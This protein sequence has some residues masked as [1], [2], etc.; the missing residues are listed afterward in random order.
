MSSDTIISETILSTYAECFGIFI[1]QINTLHSF[2]MKYVLFFALILQLAVG[3]SAHAQSGDPSV[4]NTSLLADVSLT[5]ASLV[6]EGRSANVSFTL[7]NN[8][9]VQPGVKYAVIL[10]RENE[11]VQTIEDVFVSAEE[12]TLAPAQ[13]VTRNIVYTAPQ[14][15][16]GT[17]TVYVQSANEAGF[18][19]GMARAG[20]L[21]L[22]EATAKLSLESGSCYVTAVDTKKYTS[23]E[24]VPL[25][26]AETLT[27][28]CVLKN[29]TAEALT[30]TPR[31]TTNEGSLYGPVTAGEGG[32]LASF[33]LAPNEEKTI[34]TELPRA[35]KGGTYAVTVS[36]DNEGSSES[37]RYHTAD[38]GLFVGNVMLDSGSYRKGDMANIRLIVGGKSAQAQQY[39]LDVEDRNG[40]SCAETVTGVLQ[41]TALYTNNT[42]KVLMTASCTN[43]VIK[44]QIV[45]KNGSIVSA[46]SY[47]VVLPISPSASSV[48]IEMDTSD[49]GGSGKAPLSLWFSI[50][51]LAV[52][53]GYF[54]HTLSKK[55]NMSIPPT[56]PLLILLAFVGFGF[57]SVPYAEAASFTQNNGACFVSTSY[58]PVQNIPTGQ[59][60]TASGFIS[61][62][63]DGVSAVLRDAGYGFSITSN[64]FGALS[65][66][67]PAPPADDGINYMSGDPG[68]DP[69]GLGNPFYPFDF[70]F[71][72]RCLPQIINN[73][74]T[75]D[76]AFFGVP[77][78]ETGGTCVAA[79]SCSY[80]CQP[81]LTW[82]QNSNT[83]GAPPPPPPGSVPA[84][85]STP[86]CVIAPNASSCSTT[87]DL[88][89]P[90]AYW[91]G[92]S[93]GTPGV[94]IASFM[95]GAHTTGV[96]I[97][98]AGQT[99]ELRP[100]FVGATVFATVQGTATCGAGTSWNG[101]VCNPVPPVP[102]AV[103][104]GLSTQTGASC[105]TRTVNVTWNPVANATSYDILRDGTVLL[106][107][108]VSPFA[109][110]VSVDG[111]THIYQVR[112]WAGGLVSA[113]SAPAVPGTA[114]A[115][116]PI[117]TG[118]LTINTCTI[119]DG[120]SSC[121]I[122]LSWM[123]TN[124]TAPSVRQ[125]GTI[126]SVASS[127]PGIPRTV[128]YG[129]TTF[130]LKDGT[131]ELDSE[132]ITIL[133]AS[134]SSW[135]NATC[136]STATP[137]PSVPCAGGEFNGCVV[138]NTAAGNTSGSCNTSTHTGT[139]SI[140]CSPSGTGSWV[141][142]GT[143]NCST[144]SVP[145][146]PPVTSGPTLTSPSRLVRQGTSVPITWDT[147]N[148]DEGL[149]TLTGGTLSGFITRDATDGVENG[150]VNQ[151]IVGRTTYALSCPS[152][153]T[154]L[155]IDVIP[156]SSET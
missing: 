45:E 72:N 25:K 149:C 20:T 83:C 141:L 135:N 84:F 96:T 132:I 125:D 124:T 156:S 15:F 122:N 136:E 37:Y 67:F 108:V 134:G 147:N 75:P 60:V 151:T 57:A 99:F 3:V 154:T 55:G 81:D 8:T 103:P 61:C 153:A 14:A 114:S 22:P 16:G 12:L 133:C 41:N 26:D 69:F 42:V 90:G 63:G 36:Y 1:L 58:D 13:S 105:G 98:Y 97:P 66:S 38:A 64:S 119:P 128:G 74:S 120:Q 65:G 2:F 51:G 87:V 104:A 76:A 59:T 62:P 18:V 77:V 27:S 11:A 106:S 40:A 148:G 113:W 24:L 152:G 85:T 146:P 5:G 101:T 107:G 121:Q 94:Y 91:T 68:P 144:I 43:P 78:G 52:G 88:F 49:E 46:D 50:I 44:I 80:T 54:Y 93:F 130:T 19:F 6:Q 145:P 31:F 142:P 150:T 35:Q 29:T 116:C 10:A 95:P 89:V 118:A 71:V 155:T 115:L 82:R 100:A 131:T 129:N 79:G 7:T 143:N 21:T 140:Q 127:S 110:T 34:V 138:Q 86:S 102:P 117:A 111:T 56:T 137:P 92:V 9:G 48:T 23:N 28:H 112:A 30:I 109:D 39:L 32:P 123:T 47:G 53:L 73:C 139:C 33:V 17:Y 70:I 126:V 4:R